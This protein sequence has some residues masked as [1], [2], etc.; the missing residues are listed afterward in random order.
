DKFG[1][2]HKTAFLASTSILL[3]VTVV[4]TLGRF[5]I[6]F[7][8]QRKLE[9]DDVFLVLGFCCLLGGFGALFVFINPMYMLTGLQFGG[10]EI[11][12][13]LPPDWLEIAYAYHQNSDI[14]L[15]LTWVA[16]VCVKFSFLFFFRKLVD[17]SSS[18]ILYWRLAL[19][20]NILVAIYGF[21]VYFIAC[22]HLTG[23]SSLSCGQ[24]PGTVRTFNFAL[25]QMILDVFGDLLILVI[26][27]RVIWQIRISW[28]QKFTLAISLCLTIVLIVITIIRATGLRRGGDTIDSQWEIYWQ[29]IS[30]EVGIILTTV[31]TF[32]SFFVSR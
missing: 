20:V 14:T 28:L 29:I 4:V 24:G 23:I 25:S 16:I 11:L 26:P 3:A 27:I 1:R 10:P 30:A 18:Y 21:M 9:A 6:R 5:Y 8:V 12:D 32:R 17:R 7:Y 19:A 22:P 31:T 2:I 13:S 15:T